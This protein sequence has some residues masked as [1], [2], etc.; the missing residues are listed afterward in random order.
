MARRSGEPVPNGWVVDEVG[1][2]TTD[3]TVIGT[4][5]AFE[6]LGGPVARHKGYGLALMVDALSMLA[7]AGSGIW[8]P[9]GP[10]HGDWTHGQ[11]FAVWRADLFVDPENYAAE[12][13]RLADQIHSLPAT[14][15]A[16][17]LL[18]GE[19]RASCRAA[20]AA[21]GIPLEP[22][23]VEAL[24]ALASEVGVRFPTHL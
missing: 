21:T 6:L 3:P 18:P 1:E 5:G 11:W 2:P 4:G 13:Q 12:M 19:R 14:D 16:G 17:A 9:T 15:G 22:R 24:R 23:T 8:Q 10:P 20:R 7:G